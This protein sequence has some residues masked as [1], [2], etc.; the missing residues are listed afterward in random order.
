M[1]YFKDIIHAIRALR[2]TKGFTLVAVSILALG[3]ATNTVVF[4]I[5]NAAMLRPLPY[6]DAERLTTVSWYVRGKIATPDV[7]AGAFYSLQDRT[8][9]FESV[10]AM[11]DME[12]GVNLSAVGPPQYVKAFRVS[13][14]F[15]ST[16]DV[17]PSL[18]R[19][20]NADEERPG[21]PRAVLLSYEVWERKFAKNPLALGR[22]V[23]I[24][25]EPFTIVGIMPA[26]FHSYPEADLWLPLQLSPGTADPGNE[27]R[28]IARLKK[29]VTRADAQR[30]LDLSRETL[31]YPLHPRPEGLRLVLEGFQSSMVGGIRTGLKLLFGAVLFVLL[32]TCTNLASLLTVR[33]ASRTRETSV[34]LALGASRAC[35]I[36]MF[37]LESMVIAF[38][39]GILGTILA[40][41]SIPFVLLLAPGNFMF[42]N[43]VNID[44]RVMLF[45]ACASILTAFVFGL[46]P[47]LRMSRANLNELLR[48]TTGNATSSSQHSR[49]GR[50]LV[51]AQAALTI[52]LLTGAGLLLRSLAGLYSTP[53][54]FDARHLWAAQLSLASKHYK[55]TSASAQF[56]G[57]LCEK[58]RNQA[59]IESVASVTGLPLERGLNLVLHPTAAPQK[60]VYVEY[61]IVSPDYFRAMQIP[62][63]RGRPFSSSDSAHETPVAIINQTLANEWWPN[64]SALEQYVAVQSTLNGVF[65]DP[66]RQ[67]IGVVG[68]VHESSLQTPASPTIFVPADQISDSIT[69]FANRTFLV[70]IVARTTDGASFAEYLRAG[71]NLMDPDLPIVSV[72]ALSD[73]LSISLA[74]PRFYTSLITVFGILALVL[75]AVGLYGLLSWQIVLRTREIGVRM[76][77]GAPRAEVVFMIVKQGVGLVLIGSLLGLLAAPMESRVLAA[78]V[79]NVRGATSVVPVYAA[80]ILAAVAALTSLLSAVRAASIEPAVILSTE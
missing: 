77:V 51:A 50:L 79:Y 25:G 63:M 30:E 64:D 4:S 42:T 35:V 43:S 75:T 37:L 28:V 62:V 76:A 19:S 21:G 7:S 45:S 31:P 5:I 58:I 11:A 59:G 70:S 71:V 55:T 3:I 69:E 15:F 10:S 23:R 80:V 52:V 54:G 47:A 17:L 56:V 20:F 16:L 66:N 12:G 18:G 72:R 68:D 40:K 27:Y 61:R 14:N 8:N 13:T 49:M 6:P 67:I 39:G 9:S 29:G 36:R 24:D 33:S 34:R 38:L 53:P 73:V 32:I 46:V 2:R 26:R 60:T 48:Q 78:I 57:Q 1:A 22:D 41:E 44:G 65:A 74:R